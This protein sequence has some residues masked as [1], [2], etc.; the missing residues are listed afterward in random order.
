MIGKDLVIFTLFR[1]FFNRIK[2]LGKFLEL[3]VFFFP[4]ILYDVDR[5]SKSFVR[6]VII[7]ITFEKRQDSSQVDDDNDPN[8]QTN[9]K[10]DVIYRI[11]INLL[12]ALMS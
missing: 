11:Q 10:E 1:F 12:Y 6:S 7:F 9:D 5:F 4:G 8:C 3:F 2:D